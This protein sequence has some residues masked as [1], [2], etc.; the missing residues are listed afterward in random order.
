M[1]TSQGSTPTASLSKRAWHPDQFAYQCEKLSARLTLL[2]TFPGCGVRHPL[3]SRQ[4]MLCG[5]P[6]RATAFNDVRSVLAP[7]PSAQCLLSQRKREVSIPIP[8]GTSRFQTG[9]GSRAASS[10]R[11]TLP[12]FQNLDACES[13]VA[14]DVA[15]PVR[16]DGLKCFSCFFDRFVLRRHPEIH[17][18]SVGHRGVEPRASWP[19]ARRRTP[20]LVPDCPAEA[21]T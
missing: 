11:F 12:S 13:E 17:I 20:R 6:Q 5:N 21:R 15:G 4:P 2:T 18:V 7:W 10:S 8:F 19:P 14:R 9:D 1:N 3:S 16:V